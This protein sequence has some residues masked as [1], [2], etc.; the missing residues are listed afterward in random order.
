VPKITKLRLNLSK[1]CLEYRGL[2]FSRTRCI[3]LLLLNW[4]WSWSWA[5]AFG[6]GLG[7]GLGLDLIVLVLVFFSVLAFWSCFHHWL[8]V[9]SSNFRYRWGNLP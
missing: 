4:S 8:Y 1:L 7:L 2:F 3:F 9:T 5:C 6:L